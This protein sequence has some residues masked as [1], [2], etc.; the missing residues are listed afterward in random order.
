MEPELTLA[1]AGTAAVGI[2]GYLILDRPAGS[3]SAPRVETMTGKTSLM[4]QMREK[5]KGDDTGNRRKQIEDTLKKIEETQKTRKKKHKSLESKLIQADVSMPVTQFM[6]ISLALGAGVGFICLMVGLPI[7]FVA[8]AGFVAGFGLPRFVLNFLINR[9]QKKFVQHF[10]DGMDIIVRGVRTGLPLGDC[11]KII[12]HESPDP[13]GA[14]FRRVVEAES[15]GVPIEV[16]LEQMYER[17]PISEVNF[18]ATVLNIQKTTGGNLGESLSNLSTV[19]RARKILAE[20][21]KA[22]S[23]EAKMSAIIIGALPL[24]VMGLVGIMS[25]DYMGDLFGTE[26][27]QRNLMIGAVMMGFGIFVMK[28]MINFKY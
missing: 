21:I 15:V 28:K 26:T 24:V 8:G 19:L 5:M 12:A 20:K 7:L 16:C 22:L 14:E 6:I 2:I 27:G 10:A 9:R 17:L 3:S 13:L 23:A 11:L 1:L 4:T 18:F 25:P